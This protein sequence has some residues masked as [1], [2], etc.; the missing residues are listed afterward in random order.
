MPS[1][2][3]VPDLPD[4]VPS[5]PSGYLDAVGGQPLL[6]AAQAAR[7]AAQEQAWADPARL[8]HLGRR[9]GLIL[10]TARASL[11]S[12]LGVRPTD[13]YFTSSGPTAA[14]L[15]IGGVVA[16]RG[17]RPAR[18]LISAVES[19]AV[20]EPAAR[21]ADTLDVLPVDPDGRVRV[22]AATEALREPAA[23]ACVQAANGEVGTR[24]PLSAIA[25][26]CRS[27]G[28]PLLVHA[29]QVI[30]RDPVPQDWDVLVASARDWGGPAGVG[31]LAVRPTARWRPDASPDR[32][33][34]GGFPDIP[35]AAAAAAALEYLLPH[36]G[37]EAARAHALVALLR[38]ELPRRVPGLR[39]VGPDEGRLPHLVT[40]TLPDVTGEAVVI[41]LDRRGIAVASGSACTADSRL[42]SQV[43]PAM[44]IAETTSLRVS[45]PF[46]CPAASVHLLLDELPAAVAAARA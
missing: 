21:A 17:D 10:D 8:H 23:L 19:L 26:L 28:V 32:G 1:R 2:E 31:I 37:T 25:D 5:P 18:V 24:Q 3:P 22:P 38:A 13:L 14:A 36:V 11:A 12:S 34:V 43:L 6:A 41:E 29:V 35:G 16:A 7:Q 39:V 44:G 9:A 27:A 42:P 20:Q 30:G 33:W 4:P 46:G 15:A 45:L 40:F